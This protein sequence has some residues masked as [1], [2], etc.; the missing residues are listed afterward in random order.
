MVS[1]SLRFLQKIGI[2]GVADGELVV[3]EDAL[4][5]G[6]KSAEIQMLHMQ[7]RLRALDALSFQR[8]HD[9]HYSTY[10]TYTSSS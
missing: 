3:L 8:E 2:I 6:R 9:I 7:H 1:E 10:F 5:L 4:H